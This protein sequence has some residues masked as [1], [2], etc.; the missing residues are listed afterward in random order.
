MKVYGF[1]NLSA[2]RLQCCS[3][4]WTPLYPGLTVVVFSAFNKY[5]HILFYLHLALN[6]M[7]GSVVLEQ[8]ELPVR[9]QS[10]T[11]SL[12]H[13]SSHSSNRK[14]LL[15][16]CISTYHML[17]CKVSCPIW[18]LCT[19]TSVF[20]PTHYISILTVLYIQENKVHSLLSLWLKICMILYKIH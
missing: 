9:A 3:M 20:S 10:S 14:K 19:F 13:S 1:T 8:G 6:L 15:C 4:A 12:V 11:A 17:S 18:P 16:Y 2:L 7:K 5:T